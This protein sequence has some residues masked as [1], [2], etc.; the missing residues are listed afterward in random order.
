LVNAR[1]AD[2]FPD[3]EQSADATGSLQA[4]GQVQAPGVG[5]LQ[6]QR[7]AAY[8]EFRKGVMFYYLPYLAA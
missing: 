3:R 4:A 1:A 7:S 6:G 5:S 2:V 8:L